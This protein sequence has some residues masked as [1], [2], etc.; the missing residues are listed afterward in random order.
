M[1]AVQLRVLSEPE[2]PRSS[3]HGSPP[4]TYSPSEPRLGHVFLSILIRAGFRIS[5]VWNVT[6]SR[7][8]PFNEVKKGDFWDAF[9][10]IFSASLSSGN[11]Q[12][13]GGFLRRER[14]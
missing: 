12:E 5:F 8:A 2:K 9:W 13:E 1:I 4:F 10:V 7:R 14:F 11:L 6:A 3:G